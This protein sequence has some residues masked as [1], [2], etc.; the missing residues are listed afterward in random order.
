MSHGEAAPF[1]L[2]RHSLV[3]RLAHS[4]PEERRM[5]FDELAAAY[6][7]VMVAYLRRRWR[8]EPA[9]AEDI[10][11][12]FLVRL[13]EKETLSA[14]EP[15]RA[16]FRTFL[17]SCLDRHALNHQRDTTAQRRGGGAAHLPLDEA[18]V[19]DLL[20]T[21]AL[22]VADDAAAEAEACFR[23]ELARTL[24]ARATARLRDE[25]HRRDRA[26]VYEVWRRYDL[27]P[28]PEVRYGAIAEALGI[29]VT[30]VTNHLHAARRRL[31][32]ITLTELERLCGT[33][34]EFR[35]EARELF[36]VQLP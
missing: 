16:R 2:T 17:R 18:V 12:S 13:W 28:E 15:G 5:A 14:Y 23:E 24:L 10:T 35:D 3:E 32:A 21:H 30:Q 33:D 7:P 27:E 36:G 4:G 31:R 25:L 26:I 34:A 1:P 9:D 19:G 11:Q 29:S 8:V 6:R 22:R 20:D